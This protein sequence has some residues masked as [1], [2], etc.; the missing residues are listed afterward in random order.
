MLYFLSEYLEM[1]YFK[2]KLLVCDLCVFLT[3]WLF[4][5]FIIIAADHEATWLHFIHGKF[6]DVVSV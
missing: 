4:Y 6:H 2:N 3:E 5:L 1:L